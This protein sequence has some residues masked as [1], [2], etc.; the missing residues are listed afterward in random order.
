M[1][2]QLE[3]RDIGVHCYE[4]TQIN[5]VQQKYTSVGATNDFG[6]K[7]GVQ[8][9]TYA[10]RRDK[11][12]ADNQKSYDDDYSISDPTAETCFNETM[13][14]FTGKTD[15]YMV[16]DPNET[17]FNR[18]ICSNT[19]V[20]YEF[21][22]PVEDTKNKI[23]DDDQYVVLDEGVYDHS[24]SSRHK[25]SDDTIY[26]HAVDNVYESGSHKRNNVGRED[27]YDHFF[28]QK[29]EDDYDISTMT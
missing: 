25:E 13:D 8:T 15:S 2:D 29:T 26:N 10:V 12:F 23:G 21:A 1:Y 17:G 14:N 22:K 4:S 18:H 24:G 16:L 19:P 3:S 11:T 28:E 9:P 5:N 27:T 7:D 6:N 20:G